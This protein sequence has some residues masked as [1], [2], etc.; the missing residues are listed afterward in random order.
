MSPSLRCRRVRGPGRSEAPAFSLG[1]VGPAAGEMG[2][3]T[4]APV[5]FEHE[6]IGGGPM[7][8]ISRSKLDRAQF[9]VFGMDRN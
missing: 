2:R 7:A 5:V 4:P 8:A 3:A 6:Q 1:T 9:L